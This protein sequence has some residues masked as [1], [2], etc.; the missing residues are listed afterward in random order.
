MAFQGNAFQGTAFQ[1]RRPDQR[2]PG[3]ILLSWHDGHRRDKRIIKMDH[4]DDEALLMIAKA[5]IDN[6]LL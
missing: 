2:R 1:M 4:D 5:F 6:V 3:G